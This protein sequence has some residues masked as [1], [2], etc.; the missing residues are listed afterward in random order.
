MKEVSRS[1]EYLIRKPDEVAYLE[2]Y[3]T[4]TLFDSHLVGMIVGRDKDKSRRRCGYSNK[5]VFFLPFSFFFMKRTL[6]IV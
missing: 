2:I 3:F 1:T 5:G 4:L 6:N